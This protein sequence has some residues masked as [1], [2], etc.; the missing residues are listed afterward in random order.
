MHLFSTLFTAQS[1]ERDL[2]NEEG[3]KRAIDWCKASSLNKVFI[4]SYR[5]GLL[6]EQD[7]LEKARD[8]FEA[9]GFIV[10][11]CVTPTGLPKVS[12]NWADGG[13]FSFPATLELMETI[14]RRTA[15]VF[16]TVMIDDFLFT[17]CTCDEC[18]KARGQRSF[19]DYHSDVMHEMSVQRILRPAHEVNPNCK[20]IIKYPLWYE[21][22]HKN[23]YDTIRQTKAFDQIWA[24]T[25]TREPDSQRWGRYPQTQGFYMM[26]WDVDLGEGKCMGGWFD[27]YTTTPPTYLEQARQT[28]LGG[29]KESM[30]FCFRA[31]EE[32]HPGMEDTQAL[33]KE[34]PGLDKLSYLIDGK[35]IVGVSIPKAPD[36]DAEQE[37]YLSSFYGM[38]G[39]PVRPQA[40]LDANADSVLLGTQALGFAGIRDYVISMKEKGTALAYSAGF[41]AYT[42]LEPCDDIAA[43]DPGDDN[44]SLMD[45]PYEQLNALRDHLL[46]PLGLQLRAPT[47]T[48]INLYDQ[49]MEVLQNFNDFDVEIDLDL[50]G[51]DGKA[52]RVAL[53]LSDDKKVRLERNGTRYHIHLPARTL[54][55]LF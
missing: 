53:T 2:G 10:H 45:M 35:G 19:D 22:F 23:G 27:P 26:A 14:F 18:D 16:D 37:R 46:T 51:R 52:R 28:I 36:V 15:A 13:C 7:L 31:L 3:L 54:A 50:Y 30:L 43:I 32:E 1:V 47:R 12:N 40:R 33:R 11:G 5:G 41:L 9:E 6:I 17:D 29:A 48:A 4:E 39:I 55:V 42:G 21:N 38:L 8:R 44:W 25:E 24:G 49:D 34:R 20:V